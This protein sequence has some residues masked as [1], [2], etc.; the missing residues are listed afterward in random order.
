[1]LPVTHITIVGLGLIGGSLAY[2]L[3]ENTDCI[4]SGIDRDPNTLMDALEHGAVHRAGGADMLE[5]AELVITA[6]AMLTPISTYRIPQAM[7][8]TKPGG[9]SAGFSSWG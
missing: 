7:G 1:M 9:V 2:A 5:D 8:K 3:R 6:S 4:L